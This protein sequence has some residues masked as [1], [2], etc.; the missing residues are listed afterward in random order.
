MIKFWIISSILF[1]VALLVIVKFTLTKF[2]TETG[3][4]NWKVWTGRATYWQLV[5][6]CSFGIAMAIMYALHLLNVSIT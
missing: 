4:K 6:L 5:S 1:V 2:R 3:E